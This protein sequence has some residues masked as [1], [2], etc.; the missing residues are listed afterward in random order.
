MHKA[1][2]EELSFLIS[3]TLAKPEPKRPSIDKRFRLKG[4]VQCLGATETQPEAINRYG[5]ICGFCTANKVR[6]FYP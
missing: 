4:T 2:I 6:G 1:I 3:Q 5:E